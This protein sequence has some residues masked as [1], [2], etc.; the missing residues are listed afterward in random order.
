MLEQALEE[1]G[2]RHGAADAIGVFCAGAK[3]DFQEHVPSFIT[4]SIPSLSFA[5]ST[6]HTLSARSSRVMCV[7]CHHDMLCSPTARPVSCPDPRHR[8]GAGAG[9]AAG[10]G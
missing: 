7:G 6:M 4:A 10:G 5:P 8:A 1:P 9:A 2:R 3:F